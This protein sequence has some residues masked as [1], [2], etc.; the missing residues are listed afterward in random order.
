[1]KPSKTEDTISDGSVL[2]CYYGEPHCSS[3]HLCTFNSCNVFLQAHCTTSA[4]F[5]TEKVTVTSFQL[6]P[7]HERKLFACPLF[8]LTFLDPSWLTGSTGCHFVCYEN[9]RKRNTLR[10]LPNTKTPTQK[11]FLNT[12][13]PMEPRDPSTHW[14]NYKWNASRFDFSAFY[15]AAD[16]RAAPEAAPE[17]AANSAL[18]TVVRAI[19]LQRFLLR[20][21]QLET[22]FCMAYSRISSSVILQ[23]GVWELFDCT[24]FYRQ[25]DDVRADLMTLEIAVTG[26]MD[27][28]LSAVQEGLLSAALQEIEDKCWYLQHY[29]KYFD[30]IFLGVCLDDDCNLSM[31][32]YEGVSLDD[33][34]TT[35][36]RAVNSWKVSRASDKAA[37]QVITRTMDFDP[38]VCVV[39]SECVHCEDMF[40]DIA[41]R[42]PVDV[43]RF[44][45]ANMEE[46]GEIY[47]DV[48]SDSDSEN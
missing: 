21:F 25:I 17:A 4:R 13:Q 48:Y 33:K 37:K 3:K 18:N 1:M 42:V 41:L 16:D 20:R 19:D 5:K 6:T 40:E 8:F 26:H 44:L 36:S 11:N 9:R 46:A 14:R 29:A 47:Q 10:S 23:N 34:F 27:E 30:A 45:V 38:S 39:A 7:I 32:E 22:H 43:H 28:G 31:S 35:D 15:A 2:G 24:R 12:N